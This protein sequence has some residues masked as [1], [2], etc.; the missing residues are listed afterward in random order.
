M[1]QD[2]RDLLAG[3]R[4][5]APERRP[6][7]IQRWNVRRVAL[8]LA[9]LVATIFIVVQAANLL[10]PV[11]D[12]P[13]AR[14][15]ECATSNTVILMAQA[16]PSA[17]AIPCIDSLPAGWTFGQAVVHN[18]RGRFW[19]NSDQAG[20]RAVVVTLSEEC[21]ISGARPAPP[22]ARGT[23]RFERSRNRGS[24]LSLLRFERFPGGC[25]TYDIDFD[26]GAPPELL[27]DV[28]RALAY[29]ARTRLVRH[30]FQDV[31]LVLCGRD[32]VCPG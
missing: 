20:G 14:S 19:L 1:K 11:Q 26:G 7:A 30:V 17:S 12:L 29:T 15:P 10:S 27:S 24:R 23:S 6:I 21:D 3:F 28:D 16:V 8:A 18:G 5:L 2:G 22:N 9:V 25:A 4:A 31:G 13:I 32:A